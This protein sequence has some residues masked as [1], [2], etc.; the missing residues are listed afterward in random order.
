MEWRREN[1]GIKYKY[2]IPPNAKAEVVLGGTTK[3][4]LPGT[5]EEFFGK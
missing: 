1:G 2:R 4:V 3:T 5:Y